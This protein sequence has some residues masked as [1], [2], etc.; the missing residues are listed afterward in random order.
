MVALTS[1]V[2]GSK[3]HRPVE[4]ILNGTS[5]STSLCKEPRL[6]QFDKAVPDMPEFH[7][8]CTQTK[9]IKKIGGRAGKSV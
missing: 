6:Q 9:Y 3:Y 2:F 1:Y 5:S 7:V 8:L 4:R